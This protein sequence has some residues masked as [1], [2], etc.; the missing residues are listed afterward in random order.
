MLNNTG[1]GDCA[2]LGRQ[3]EFLWNKVTSNNKLTLTNIGQNINS[4]MQ[5]VI[6]SEDVVERILHEQKHNLPCPISQKGNLFMSLSFV[7]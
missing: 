3:S 6:L 1:F 2:T 7:H 4:S 5:S